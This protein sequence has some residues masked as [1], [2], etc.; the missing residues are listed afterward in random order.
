MLETKTKYLCEHCYT[1]YSK[2][3]NAQKCEDI[4]LPI[5]DSD[6]I[7]G[8]QKLK[9]GTIITYYP[10]NRFR[11]PETGVLI[12]KFIKR[13]KDKHMWVLLLNTKFGKKVIEIDKDGPATLI[14][15]N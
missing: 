7:H 11:N 3:E 14:G 4:G 10:K 6:A 15:L 8:I 13:E 5:E 9:N 1:Q 12:A 2:K